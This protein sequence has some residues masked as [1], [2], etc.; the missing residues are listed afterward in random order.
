LSFCCHFAVCCHD[1]PFQT[2]INI[3]RLEFHIQKGVYLPTTKIND[4][5]QERF[6]K[7]LMIDILKEV[8][9]AKRNCTKCKVLKPSNEDNFYP[10]YSG[11]KDVNGRRLISGYGTICKTCLTAD[12]KV[13]DGNKYNEGRYAVVKKIIKQKTYINNIEQ[14]NTLPCQSCGTTARVRN[15]Y[16]RGLFGELKQSS[17][18]TKL[19][20]LIDKGAEILCKACKQKDDENLRKKIASQT[21]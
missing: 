6:E 1:T 8:S 15:A 9:I 17:M 19:A 14:L 21:P 10:I 11:Q 12:K 3:H 20:T 2:K 4:M 5:S 16:K 7:M 13:R 18:N